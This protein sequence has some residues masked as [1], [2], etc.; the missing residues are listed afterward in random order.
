MDV[1]EVEPLHAP[2]EPPSA[3]SGRALSTVV[4]L[5]LEYLMFASAIFLALLLFAT[6]V[7]LRILDRALG[8]RLRE[9]VVDFLAWVSPG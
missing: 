1:E 6:R 4:G 8:L 3:T 7:P 5:G 2:A 9:R